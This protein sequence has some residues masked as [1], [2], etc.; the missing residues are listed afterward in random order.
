M[1]IQTSALTAIDGTQEARASLYEKVVA[2][3]ERAGIQNSLLG[4]QDPDGWGYDIHL[5]VP[6]NEADNARRHL[7]DLDWWLMLGD[8]GPWRVARHRLYVWAG[9]ANVHLHW[10]VPTAPGRAWLSAGA[11]VN[12]HNPSRHLRSLLDGQLRL[13]VNGARVHF[14]RLTLEVGPGVFVPRHASEMLVE[15]VLEVQREAGVIADI[16]TGCG[17]VALS[18]AA[19]GLGTHVYGV[20]ISRRALRWAKRNARRLELEVDFRRGG[21][22]DPIPDSDRLRTVVANVP[23]VAEGQAVHLPDAPGSTYLGRDTDGLG[24]HRK[25]VQDAH[26]RLVTGGHLVFQLG[27]GQIET[28][29][30][31]L[32]ANGYEPVA[33]HE[34]G[35]TAVLAAVKSG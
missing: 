28:L 35:S 2:R 23:C 3:F 18:L 24:L 17:A 30:D 6:A 27:T 33:M 10:R 11:V 32:S 15:T 12:R 26:A 1:S 21:L 34:D 7:E 25:L 5:L 13:G 22:L 9:V 29:S 8:L 19:R 4:D 31:F 20:D 14:D 16:G